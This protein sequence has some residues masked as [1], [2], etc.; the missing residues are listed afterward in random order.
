MVPKDSYLCVGLRLEHIFIERRESDEA[1]VEEVNGRLRYERRRVNKS[2]TGARRTS[3]VGSLELVDRRLRDPGDTA[4]NRL[5]DL[6][7]TPLLPGVVPEK[8][9]TALRRGGRVPQVSS[10]VGKRIED[11][12]PGRDRAIADGIECRMSLRPLK[13]LSS[14]PPHVNHLSEDLPEIAIPVERPGPLAR[15]AGSEKSKGFADN[16]VAVR[17]EEGRGRMQESNDSCNKLCPG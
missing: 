3:T 9:V 5:H 2:S 4:A 17:L 6:Y 12:I 10:S 14:D 1:K 13:L 7:V 15:G 8:A 16:R 11:R